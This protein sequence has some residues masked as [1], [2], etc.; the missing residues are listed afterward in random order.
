MQSKLDKTLQQQNTSIL[1]I[2]NT[3]CSF[4]KSA[5]QVSEQL[6]ISYD[7]LDIHININF[8]KKDLQDFWKLGLIKGGMNDKGIFKSY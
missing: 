8:H 6:S 7:G 1:Q 5:K 3:H 2:I 4:K